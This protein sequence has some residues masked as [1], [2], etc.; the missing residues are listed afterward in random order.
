MN[1]AQKKAWS[2]LNSL[3]QNSLFLQISES[4]STWEAGEI[5]RL[6]HYKYI[7]IRERSVKFFKM[8]SDFFEIHP[9]IFRPDSPC[10][11]RFQ[12]YI[13]GCIEKRLTRT[14]ASV[15]TGDSTMQL[16][17]ITTKV[18]VRNMERL[19]ES[20]HTNP[21]D[22][23]TY[24]L[25]LEF[26]RWN[27]FRILPMLLQQPSAFKRRLNK[28]DKI[29]IRYIMRAIPTWKLKRLEERFKTTPKCKSKY[30]VTL[31]KEGLYKGGYKVIPV[32]ANQE[33][34][35]VFSKLYVYIFPDRLYA[36]QFGFMVANFFIRTDGVRLGQ[37]FWPEYRACIETAINYNQ[38]N[39]IE[40]SVKNLE[41]AYYRKN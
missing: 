32:K 33:V 37:K 40:F 38:I 3:E 41:Q 14:Q 6:S 17:K 13:E 1:E 29:Y 34:I 36:D 18:I 19:K 39:N 35:E 30:W 7:E 24:R 28:K 5:L 21:W 15:Y 20:Q 16:S 23:D 22:R 10:E 11:L 4:K 12:D 9:S 27:N 26:D 31:I 8:F 25:I 2:C